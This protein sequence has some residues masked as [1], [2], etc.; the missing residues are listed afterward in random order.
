MLLCLTTVST[1]RRHVCLRF[2]LSKQ[3]NHSS[4]NVLQPSGMA[5]GGRFLESQ[6]LSLIY[7]KQTPHSLSWCNVGASWSCRTN[8]SPRCQPNTERVTDTC[9]STASLSHCMDGSIQRLSQEKHGQAPVSRTQLMHLLITNKN[10]QTSHGLQF[11]FV[12]VRIAKKAY[13]EWV[14]FNLSQ[15]NH[16]HYY[17]CKKK[18]E[19]QNRCRQ[20][21]FW[22]TL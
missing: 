3:W 1:W 20:D 11:S 2:P 22:S 6:R 10:T 18:N 21:Y 5:D 8:C 9:C 12:V 16:H 14:L 17:Y 19:P 15:L 13:F 7:S 4:E